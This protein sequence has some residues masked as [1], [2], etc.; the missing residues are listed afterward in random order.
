MSSEDVCR[1]IWRKVGENILESSD[2]N[3]YNSRLNL[4]GRT[5]GPIPDGCH[6][7]FLITLHT[8]DGR[9]GAWRLNRY[10]EFLLFTN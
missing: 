4:T 6:Q 3:L 1:K 5:V 9:N 2:I 10:I 7:L 8:F